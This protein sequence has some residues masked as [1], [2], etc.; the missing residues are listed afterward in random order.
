MHAES[1]E[2]ALLMYNGGSPAEDKGEN[3]VQLHGVANLL[4][5]FPDYQA[6]I[7][8]ACS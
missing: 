5:K 2:E 7:P 4:S 8:H 3:G 6:S 1:L